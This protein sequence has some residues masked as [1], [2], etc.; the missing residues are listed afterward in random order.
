MKIRILGAHN[1]ESQNTRLLS[2][3]VDDILVLDAG[4]LTSSLSFAE[5][6]KVEAVL[7]THH[8]YDH[9]RDIPALAMNSYLSGATFR[10]YAP[11]S[12]HDALTTRLLDGKFYP[13]FLERPPENPTVKFTVVEPLKPE[14]VEGYSILPV[15]LNHSVPAVG[16]QVTASDG[17]AIFYSGDTGPDMADCWRQVSPQLLI[18]EVTASNRF[19]SFGRESKHLTPDLLKEELGVFL[20]LKGYLPRVVTVHMS[21]GLEDES[22]AEIATVAEELAITISPAYE[23]MEISV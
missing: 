17:K 15:P 13:N 8:H 20:E 9:V 7:L 12:V 23:G 3:L 1:C 11:P 18:I 5:Q 21:P 19:T 6:Q 16:Y 22:R 2:L 14:Q 10:I 4:G